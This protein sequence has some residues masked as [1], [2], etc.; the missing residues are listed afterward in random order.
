MNTS[1]NNDVTFARE[2]LVTTWEGAC[3]WPNAFV[4][5]SVSVKIM[6]EGKCCS[7]STSIVV[8]EIA[9]KGL[10]SGV[11]SHVTNKLRQVLKL[12]ITI[13]AIKWHFLS[14]STCFDMIF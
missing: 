2:G 4:D 12:L 3:K 10:F 1:V 11:G 14:S 13:R 7:T 8:E 9:H 6:H 5:A